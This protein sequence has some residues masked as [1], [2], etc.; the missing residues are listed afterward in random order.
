[1][2]GRLGF[3]GGH[4]YAPGVH[5]HGL[6][7]LR[8]SIAAVA[9]WAVACSAAPSPTVHRAK[10]LV[11]QAE[12]IEPE[13]TPLLQE[14]AVQYGGEMIGLHH[15]LK[16]QSSTE[17]KLNTIRTE[18]PGTPVSALTINDSLRY[19]MRVDDDPPG[20]HVAAIQ[21][22]LSALEDRGYAVVVIKNYW[23]RGDN[24]SGVNTVLS[25]P[26]GV[27][28][29]LQFHT[30]DSLRVQQETRA[31]YEE[32]RLVATPVERKRE[33]FDDMARAWDDVVI[34]TDILIPE[35]LHPKEEI[36]TRPRP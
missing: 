27:R 10:T 25:H 7:R 4:R 34:P 19:T 21:T 2:A 18:V 31:Q 3:A 29:E 15:R 28:W 17:R 8:L 23:P 24:Y 1:V 13:V 22:V 35:S 26:S 30:G 32:L 11:A 33:L 36:I 14:L 9:L 6:L 16:T 5:T 20:R 12:D